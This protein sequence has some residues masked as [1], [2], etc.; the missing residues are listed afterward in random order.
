METQL[1]EPTPFETWFYIPGHDRPMKC[2]GRRYS[3]FSRSSE[4]EIACDHVYRSGRVQA[5]SYNVVKWK[6]G[7]FVHIMEIAKLP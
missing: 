4:P 1:L 6:D 7:L 5:I 2:Q 3:V